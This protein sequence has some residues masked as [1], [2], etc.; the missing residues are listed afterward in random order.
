MT[1]S[2]GYRTLK[3][4]SEILENNCQSNEDWLGEVCA[5]YTV[6]VKKVP[7]PPKKKL[8]FS[9]FT[10]VKYIS[11][12]FYQFVDSLYAQ[13]FTTFGQFILIFNKMALTFL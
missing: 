5:L 8:F 13:L 11:V 3:L 1:R 6:W 10:Q 7:P 9:I 2:A 4:I 12:K